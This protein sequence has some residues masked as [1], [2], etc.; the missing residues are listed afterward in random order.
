MRPSRG[1]F[2]ID[3]LSEPIQAGVAVQQSPTIAED[4]GEFLFDVAQHFGA[5]RNA[6]VGEQR[7]EFGSWKNH[8]QGPFGGEPRRR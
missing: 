5:E 3:L 7:I 2:A 6:V 1:Q 8:F 4:V